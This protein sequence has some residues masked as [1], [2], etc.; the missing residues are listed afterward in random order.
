MNIRRRFFTLYDCGW[1][2]D[3]ILTANSANTSIGYC[4][5]SEDLLVKYYEK[6]IQKGLFRIT[7]ER[8]FNFTTNK[9]FN[10]QKKKV[11]NCK[12]YY[13]DR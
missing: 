4:A 9:T 2:K 1:M 5:L 3:Y 13:K 10:F 12:N 6:T 11:Q 8:Y 7:A